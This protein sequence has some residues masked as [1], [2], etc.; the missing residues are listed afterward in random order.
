MST[1]PPDGGVA[2]AEGD[3]ESNPL[4]PEPVVVVDASTY[5]EAWTYRMKNVLLGRPLVSEQLSSER[6]PKRLAFGVLAP[7]MI[8][9]SR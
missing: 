1:T 3:G 9:S 6:L 5:P 2:T 4:A 7:D 8:S